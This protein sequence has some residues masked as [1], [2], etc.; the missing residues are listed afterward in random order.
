MCK[1]LYGT[2][3]QQLKC[4][5]YVHMSVFSYVHAIACGVN[6][7]CVQAYVYVRLLSV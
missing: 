5:N 3:Q 7:L 2:N 6:Y 4:D 1:K